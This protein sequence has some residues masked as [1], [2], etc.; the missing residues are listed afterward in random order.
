MK[1][2]VSETSLRHYFQRWGTISDIFIPTDDGKQ[3][4][5]GYIT[6]A[7]LFK[8]HPCDESHPHIVDGCTLFVD[9]NEHSPAPTSED[10]FSSTLAANNATTQKL[11]D[12]RKAKNFEHHGDA[13]ASPSGLKLNANEN[14]LFKYR[15]MPLDETITLDILMAYFNHY[16]RVVDAYIP[17]EY[18]KTKTKLFGYLIMSISHESP[19]LQHGYHLINGKRIRIEI[20]IPSQ[21]GYFKSKCLIV[22]ASP[23]VISNVSEEQLK[24]FFKKFGKVVQVRKPIDAKNKTLPHYAFVEFQ[25]ETIVDAVISK[26]SK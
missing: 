10:E 14:M 23:K 22:S 24:N 19:A 4:G 11:I 20:D 8:K 26:T 13:S 15:V 16:G 6:F 21:H 12:V 1:P 2:E 9:R 17:K 3:R 18:G 25:S 7:N 5:F